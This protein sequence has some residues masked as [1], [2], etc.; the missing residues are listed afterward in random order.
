MKNLLAVAMVA[1]SAAVVAYVMAEDKNSDCLAVGDGVAAFNVTDVT[2]PAAGEEL[3]YRCRYGGRP[4]VSIFAKAMTDDVAKLTKE[5]DAVVGENKDKKMAAFVVML[6]D[7]PESLNDVLKQVA[8]EHSIEHTPLT[9]FNGVD[10][11]APYKLSKDADVTVMMW[12]DSKVQVN[13]SL[14]ANDLTA[15]KIAALVKNTGKILN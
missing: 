5:I 3:C 8:K 11:P 6:S 4:V 1:A 15:E 7:E 12:V 14:K 2:G 13:E 10:G 9:T